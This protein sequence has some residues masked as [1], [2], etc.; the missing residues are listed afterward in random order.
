[1]TVAEVGVTQRVPP[2]APRPQETGFNRQGAKNA[3]GETEKT[4]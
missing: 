3:K 1:M 2:P 4:F